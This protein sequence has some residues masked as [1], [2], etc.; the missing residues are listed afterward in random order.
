[1]TDEA[2]KNSLPCT[3]GKS[4][5]NKEEMKRC[6]CVVVDAAREVLLGGEV[7]NALLELL[8]VLVSSIVGHDV[9]KIIEADK[10]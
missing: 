7:A 6:L 4:C 1:M 10:K 8:F 5:D 9:S 3:H 2:R